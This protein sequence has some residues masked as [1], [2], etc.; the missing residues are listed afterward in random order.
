MKIIVLTGLPKGTGAYKTRLM[1]S[2][3]TVIVH[4]AAVDIAGTERDIVAIARYHVEKHGWPGIGYHYVVA[5]D[6]TVYKTNPITAISYH[7]AGSNVRSIGVCLAGDLNKARPTPQQV[8]AVKGLVQELQKQLGKPLRLLG[9]GEVYP[10]DCP[11]K[12]GRAMVAA[13][14]AELGA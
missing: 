13:L 1:S 7:A 9:H 4:H 8:E 2:V 5:R 10:T 12:W 3:D 14:R 11:G 6:G